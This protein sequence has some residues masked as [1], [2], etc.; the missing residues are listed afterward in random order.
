MKIK[1]KPRELTTTEWFHIRELRGTKMTGQHMHHAR[2]VPV[3]SK[4]PSFVKGVG[5][6]YYWCMGQQP[7]ARTIKKIER[8]CPVK[9]ALAYLKH[10]EYSSRGRNTNNFNR[11]KKRT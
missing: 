3:D 10:Y 7:D 1:T 4:N 11:P 2:L 6:V 5:P 9:A 8:H